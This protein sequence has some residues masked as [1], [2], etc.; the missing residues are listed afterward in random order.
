MRSVHSMLRAR[1]L[2]SPSL[3]P[4]HGKLPGTAQREHFFEQLPH[5]RRVVARPSTYLR[6]AECT[7]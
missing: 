3:P 5:Y 6:K 7:R 2:N 4:Y 1:G